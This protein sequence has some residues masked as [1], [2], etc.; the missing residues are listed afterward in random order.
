MLL[1]FG[2]EARTCDG[3]VHFSNSDSN[4]ARTPTVQGS[5]DGGPDVNNLK[6]RRKLR[7]SVRTT[8]LLLRRGG[9]VGKPMPY[10]FHLVSS[11]STL[12]PLTRLRS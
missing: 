10:A 9:G 7:R 5:F 6:R 11:M 1:L 12:P 3:C 8:G 4:G 2:L